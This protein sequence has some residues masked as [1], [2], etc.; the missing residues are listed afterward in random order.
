MKAHIIERRA[1]Y[2]IALIWLCSIAIAAPLLFTRSLDEFQWRDHLEVFC[3]DQWPAEETLD[4]ITGIAKRT[5]PSRVAYWTILSVILYFLPV[6]VMAA[7]YVVIMKTLLTARAP[8]ETVGAE[9]SVQ[10][11]MKRKVRMYCAIS[12]YVMVTFLHTNQ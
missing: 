10:T 3:I 9:I 1:S 5:Y 6:L 12:H 4:A 8:G 11:K 2:S 7:V